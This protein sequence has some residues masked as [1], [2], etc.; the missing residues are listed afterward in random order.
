MSLQN[1][2]NIGINITPPPQKGTTIGLQYTP[3]PLAQ[4]GLNMIMELS[5]ASAFLNIVNPPIRKN[6]TVMAHL[7]TG[8][9]LTSIDH[10]LA[11][12]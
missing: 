1:F 10:S 4:L 7:D 11:I 12:H 9:S 5:T 3:I 6:I 8:A 2:F